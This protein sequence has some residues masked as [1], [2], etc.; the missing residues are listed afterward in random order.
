MGRVW[1]PVLGGSLRAGLR[2]MRLPPRSAAGL[3]EV[4]SPARHAFSSLA[5]L[6]RSVSRAERKINLITYETFP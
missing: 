3:L 2:G 5:V 6:N 1:L 4:S